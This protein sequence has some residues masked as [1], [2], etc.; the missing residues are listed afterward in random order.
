MWTGLKDW[1]SFYSTLRS[2][3]GAIGFLE[4][5]QDRSRRPYFRTFGVLFVGVG[6]V[7]NFGTLQ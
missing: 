7:W 3:T 4:V 6:R 2:P 5:G 1:L